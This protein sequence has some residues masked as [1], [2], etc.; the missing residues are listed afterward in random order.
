MT[1]QEF[2]VKLFELNNQIDSLASI[3][4]ELRKESTRVYDKKNELLKDRNE[5]ISMFQ[6]SI[7]K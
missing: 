6:K 3:E 1:I 4:A 5:L 2:L 7:E